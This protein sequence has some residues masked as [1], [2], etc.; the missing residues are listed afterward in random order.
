MYIDQITGDSSVNQ[1]PP[2]FVIFLWILPM[3]SHSQSLVA[4]MI[5]HCLW[6]RLLIILRQH[7]VVIQVHSVIHFHN[8]LHR[9]IPISSTVSITTIPYCLN[10]SWC[11]NMAR[12]FRRQNHFWKYFRTIYEIFS[13][14][15]DS[16]YH[17]RK[18]KSEEKKK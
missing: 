10:I 17:Y 2:L 8:S 6:K 4:K 14:G 18:K 9:W 3:W 12:H 11:F 13:I 16:S 7:Y 1:R 15:C 5:W